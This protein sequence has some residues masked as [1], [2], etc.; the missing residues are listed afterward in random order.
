MQ[1]N[2]IS[3]LY[4]HCTEDKNTWSEM[5]DHIQKYYLLINL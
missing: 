2:E 1:T 5:S 3:A 4:I